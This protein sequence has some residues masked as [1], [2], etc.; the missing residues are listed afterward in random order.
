MPP[1]LRTEEDVNG[2]SEFFRRKILFEQHPASVV[3]QVCKNAWA[4]ELKRAD[5]VWRGGTEAADVDEE[6]GRFYLILHGSVGVYLAHEVEGRLRNT[7]DDVLTQCCQTKALWTKL[8]QS[9]GTDVLGHRMGYGAHLVTLVAG[10]AFGEPSDFG[11]VLR[12][13][14]T[15]AH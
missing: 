3:K 9:G 4:R 8:G 15:V 13:A 2:L 5:L 12:A 7:E 1:E 11:P 10:D 6:E 14:T